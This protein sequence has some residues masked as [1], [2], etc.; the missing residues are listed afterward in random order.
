MRSILMPLRL[1]MTTA[2]SAWILA[3]CSAGGAP[4]SAANVL[5]LGQL[6]QQQSVVS[7]L[8]PARSWILPTAKTTPLLYVSDGAEGFVIIYPATGHNPAPIGQLTGFDIAAGL[9]VDNAGNLYV[10]DVVHEEVQVFHRGSTSAF[11][12]LNVHGYPYGEGVDNSGNVYVAVGVTGSQQ[13]FVGIYPPGATEP[14]STLVDPSRGFSPVGVALDSHGNVF[15]SYDVTINTPPG[16]IDEFKAGK[17]TPTNLGITVPKGVGWLTVDLSGNLIVPG[18]GVRVYPPGSKKPS[19]TFG[20][21]M[22]FSP[23]QVA[24]NK[25]GSQVYVGE[26]GANAP[27]LN[28]ARVYT[29]PGGQLVNTITNQLPSGNPIDGVLGIAVDPR[30]P[31]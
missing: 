30:S 9:A 23:T 7:A 29:Y 26:N 12:I 20:E 31:L 19:L 18:G 25:A 13:G 1:I 5:P 17:T 2:V 14:S 22:K 28:S 6:T 3:G 16:G 10:A 21:G 4:P 15:V 24:L 8:A 27:V 11:E